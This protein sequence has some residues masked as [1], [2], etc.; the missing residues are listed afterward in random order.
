[1]SRDIEI[2]ELPLTIEGETE[3]AWKVTDGDETCWLPKSMLIEPPQDLRDGTHLFLVPEWLAVQRD[4][5]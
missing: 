2:V 5:I 3:M 4:L 1:M